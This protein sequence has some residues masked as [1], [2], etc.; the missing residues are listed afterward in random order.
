[1]SDIVY[2]IE[3]LLIQSGKTSILTIENL[4]FKAQQIHLIAGP[5]GSGKTTLMKAM[6]NLI[7]VKKDCIFYKGKDITIN[8]EIVRNNSVYVHQNPYPL[9]G[10]VYY[11]ISYGLKLRKISEEII[12]TKVDEILYM[13]NIKDLKNKTAYTL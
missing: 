10:S 3:N 13:L 9:K 11:N 4:N 8:N 12:Q 2:S 5:N 1:M 6:N 7:R